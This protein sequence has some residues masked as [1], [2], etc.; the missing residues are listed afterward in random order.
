M[1]RAGPLP[2]ADSI[3]PVAQYDTHHEGHSVIGGYVYHGRAIPRLRGKYV[4]GDF[5]L[6]FKFPSGPHD[7]GRVL[8]M[9]A[10]GSSH[11]LR[12]ISEV[13][14]LPGGSLSLSVLGMGQD[15]AGEIYVMGNVNGV[16]FGNNGVV[17]RLAPA[18][19]APDD[20]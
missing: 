10:G 8:T 2:A 20:D 17:M 19:E 16:P 1:T 6:L 11:G 4:F 12:A 7:Y 13:L 9:N 18:P 14:I 3:D 15:S 5:S